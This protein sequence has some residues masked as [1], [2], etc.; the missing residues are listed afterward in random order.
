MHVKLVVVFIKPKDICLWAYHEGVREDRIIA[1]FILK[2][3]TR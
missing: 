1:P 2:L 3:F